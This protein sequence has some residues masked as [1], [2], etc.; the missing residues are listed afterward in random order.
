MRGTKGGRMRQGDKKRQGSTQ[1][2][3]NRKEGK[4]IEVERGGKRWVEVGR[5]RK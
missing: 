4:V 3:G 2:K 1:K 5:G